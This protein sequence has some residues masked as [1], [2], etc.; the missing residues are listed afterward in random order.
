M[1][2]E[3]KKTNYRVSTFLSREELDFLDELEKDMYFTYGIHIPRATLIEEIIEGLRE[4]GTKEE[5]EA[6]LMKRFKEKNNDT[7]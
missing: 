5:I 1:S 7:L 6:E 4:K 2:K 3:N